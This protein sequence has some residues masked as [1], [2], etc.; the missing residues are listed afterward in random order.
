[1]VVVVP[2]EQDSKCGGTKPTSGEIRDTSPENGKFFHHRHQIFI[3]QKGNVENGRIQ[4]RE[5]GEVVG[6]A[7]GGAMRRRLSCS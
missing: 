1:L 4:E 6:Q 3:T 5:R 2:H 7:T